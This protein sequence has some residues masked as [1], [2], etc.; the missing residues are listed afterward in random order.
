MTAWEIHSVTSSGVF[1]WE[2]SS[3]TTDIAGYETV[4]NQDLDGDGKVGI[5]TT[6]LNAVTTDTTGAQL[7]VSDGG[8]IY[9]WDGS[10]TSNILAVTDPNGGAPSFSVNHNW[11]DGGYVM[12]PYAVTTID[13]GAS[14]EHFRV[15][16]KHTDS[17]SWDDNNDGTISA[18]EVYTNENWELFKVSTDGA[19]DWESNIWTDSITTWEDEFGMDL[20]GDGDSSGS[21]AITA[22]TTDTTSESDGVTLGEDLSLI[23]I[24]EPTRPY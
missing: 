12:A 8:N 11:G 1:D 9:I 15:L 24:S 14:T 23:H 10:D 22:R 7:M 21:V 2:N 20:N 18:S 3:F 19:I 16:V 4:F 6:A 13:S 5:D 17:Y